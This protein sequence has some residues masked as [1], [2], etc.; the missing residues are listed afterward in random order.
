MQHLE[1][2]VG[3]KRL[4]EKKVPLP[5]VRVDADVGKEAKE[6]VFFPSASV[7]PC[8]YHRTGAAYSFITHPVDGQL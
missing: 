6:R 2:V 1:V 8:H 3:V 7:F 4:I 5:A